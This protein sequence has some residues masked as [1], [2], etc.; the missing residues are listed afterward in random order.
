LYQG[1]SDRGPYKS[2]DRGLSFHRILGNGWPVTVDNFSWSG[3]YYRNYEDCQIVCSASCTSSGR[4][5]SGGTTDFAV[6]R[7]NPGVIYS[8]FGGTS[9]RST[10][11][12]V[13]KSSDGGSTWQPSGFQV[14]DGFALN[15]ETCV[16]Y[17]FRYLAIDPS[18]D[19][20]VFAAME[21]PLTGEGK[22]YRT[23]DGGAKWSVV[24]TTPRFIAGVD[25]SAA[26]PRLVVVATAAAVYKS[27]SAGAAESWQSITPED[28][29]GLQ[30][31]RI[32]PHQA[33][34]FVLGTNSQGI[35]YTSDGGV[36]W[37]NNR[38]HELFE[39]KLNQA[40]VVDLDANVRTA[41]N[42]SERMLRNV[43][44]IVFDP[45]EPDV[46]YVAGTQYGRA[47][48]G[49]AKVTAHGQQWERLALEGLSSRNI[50]DLALDAAGEY[51]YA[52]TFD[53]SYRLKL[54]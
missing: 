7:Q 38:F 49:V 14:E 28:A 11:G 43:S 52:G 26:D 10:A 45:I 23:M 27:E 19:Q 12:G 5:S 48:F 33:Q 44:A 34:T 47:S 53:G 40:G 36:T 15:P 54:R 41:Y 50:F 30:T 46:F 1:I 4:V 6:S 51:L 32:A 20:I 8:A 13:N 2:V 31:V 37:S 39:Q 25:V 3:P 42:P 29:N 22:L 24:L 16:P 21:I 9:G 18:N 35:Y 17:G